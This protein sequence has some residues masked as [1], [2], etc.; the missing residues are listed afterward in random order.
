MSV[1]TPTT[2]L[3]VFR[4]L[5]RLYPPDYRERYGE[6]MEGF[7]LRE[8]EAGGGALFWLRLLA[9]HVEAAWAVRRRAA[10][11]DARE[12][13]MRKTLDDVGASIRSLRRSPRFT[14]FAVGTLALG[15]G[16]VTAVFT[17][18]DRI[19]L[20]P[21][22]YPDSERLVLVGI[23]PRHDPG[24]QG[25]L[26]PAL[27][28]ALRAA[29]GPA[30]GIVAARGVEAILRGD[31]DPE[32]VDVTE[33]SEGFFE[34]LGVAPAAGRLLQPS[35]HTPGASPVVVLQGDVDEQ[36]GWAQ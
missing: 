31:A 10:R 32:R 26:S 23:D 27:F 5:L 3:R 24:S 14:L 6:E 13:T 34:L 33:V 18:V 35:D 36:G 29:P 1:E 16:S 25:P 9:D 17:V 7:F 8:L 22:P 28:A 4:R 12:G 19:L 11:S 30:D 21:L 15:V 20:R 2:R